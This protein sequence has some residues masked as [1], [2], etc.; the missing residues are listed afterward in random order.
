MPT[1]LTRLDEIASIDGSS[2]SVLWLE[3]VAFVFLVLMVIA[4]PHSIAATQIAWLTGMTAW[5]ARL[6]LKPRVKFRFTALDAALWAFFLWSVITSLTSYAPD[7]SLNKLRGVAV[8]LIFY[9]VLYNTRTRRAAHFLAIAL[10]ASCMV[11]VLWTPVQRLIGRGVEIHGLAPDSPLAKAHLWEGDTLLEANGKKLKTPDDVVAAIQQNESTKIKFYRPDFDFVVEVKRADLIGSGDSMSQLGITSWKKSRNW[12]SSG[13]YGHYATYSEVLQ[14]IASLVMGL[15]VAS[16][17]VV[18]TQR[19]KDAKTSPPLPF[20]LTPL[21]LFCLLAMS[22]ALLLTVTRASQ[23]AFMI[24]AAAIV[25]V[26][27]GRKWLVA[28]VAIGLPIAIV[29]LLFLQQ[30]RQV[31]FFDPN[32]DSIKWRQTVWREGYDLWTSSPR[33]FALGVGMDSTQRFAREW[34]MFD[35]GRLNPGH[36]HSTPL[37]LLV[38]R[39][40]PAFLLWLIVLGVYART[41]WKGVAPANSQSAIRD[42]QYQGI[43]LGCL[44]GAIGFFASGLVH[45]NLGDQEVAMMLFLLMGLSVGIVRTRDRRNE[46]AIN[47]HA[48]AV[49]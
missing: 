41:L 14:L 28:A 7:I 3:R 37:N 32:D 12:R 47:G 22:L 46:E 25:A 44:G 45:Y 43:L 48:F 40:L 35:D 2:R 20:S 49:T 29:G 21:L 24:S 11:N 26:G 34:H 23:L 42:P 15:L 5:I 27:L 19:R 6:F 13:F 4:A 10:I 38:E 18:F 1:V 30:S 8:F 9:F 16:L 31:G 17:G 33:N 39:G 36:F